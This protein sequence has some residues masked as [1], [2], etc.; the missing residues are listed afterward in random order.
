MMEN[1]MVNEMENVVMEEVLGNNAEEVVVEAVKKGSFGKNAL[2]VAGLT[3][4]GYAAYKLGK[5]VYNKRKA[6][7]KDADITDLNKP[8]AS[9]DE[10]LEA[11]ITEEK[12]VDMK[13][14]KKNN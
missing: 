1:V 3:A 10:I 14:K 7:Q 8:E 5:K 12:V 9:E 4:A 11:V 6:K 13:D 2:I